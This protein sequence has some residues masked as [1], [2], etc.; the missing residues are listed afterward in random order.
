MVDTKKDWEEADK[1]LAKKDEED[2][3]HTFEE[4]K[5]KNKEWSAADKLTSVANAAPQSNWSSTTPTSNLI[6]LPTQNISSQEP[7]TIPTQ[8]ISSPLNPATAMIQ[9]QVVDNS[10]LNNQQFLNTQLE[11]A[12]NRKGLTTDLGETAATGYQKQADLTQKAAEDFTKQQQESQAAFA[13]SMKDADARDA[14][15]KLKIQQA[16]AEQID[17]DRYWNHK[18]TGGKILAGIGI[19]LG[20]L[21]QG[22]MRG[23]SNQAMDVINRAIDQDIDAQ[24][25]H[26]NNSWKDISTTRELDDNSFNRQM[27]AQTWQN[28]YRTAALENVKLQLQSTAAKT[29]SDTVRQ[30]ALLGIQD[31]TDQQNKIKNQQ[32][33][34]GQQAAMA[35]QANLQ[36]LTNDA[37]KDTQE[38]MKE[39]ATQEA[40]LASVYSRPKYRVLVHSGLGPNNINTNNLGPIGQVVPKT[41][42]GSESVEQKQSR[43]VFT[44]VPKLGPNGIPLLNEKGKPEMETVP[45]LAVNKE[46]ADKYHDHAEVLPTV[47]KLYKDLR[48][49]WSNNDR[50]KYTAAR[51][52]LIELAPKFYGFNRGPSVAQVK[53]TIGAAI[54]E[55]KLLSIGTGNDV[56]KLDNLGETFKTQ[57]DAMR[58]ST[59][60]GDIGP[61]PY[62]FETTGKSGGV[63]LLPSGGSVEK[64]PTSNNDIGFKKTSSL[65]NQLGFKPK[66]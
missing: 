50:G 19:I 51:E 37:D 39:G 30:N 26:I 18:S 24:K 36:K 9:N 8:N 20:G 56:Q 42:P 17:P 45:K 25:E 27:H 16:H 40:A 57:A 32:Y 65:D 44:D 11:S 23:H 48:D 49:S 12:E 58:K 38:L 4:A 15:L 46:A 55:Y 29:Q 6:T 5:A 54:P 34:L 1:L 62:K 35:G 59:F 43:T 21:G 7:L 60:G 47:E 31:L 28:N 41:A 2:D 52:N 10:P 22:L 3:K 33:I 64:S 13:Q 53:D 61:A 14:S 63:G 66:L